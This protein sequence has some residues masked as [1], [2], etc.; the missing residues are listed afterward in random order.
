MFLTRDDL[1]E[2]TGRKRKKEICAWLVGR[3]YPHEIG[4]DGWPKVLRSFVQAKLGG[5]A[6]PSE[7]RL[8]LETSR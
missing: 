1:R 4:D 7:P 2:L 3:R 6:D 8:H 5:K